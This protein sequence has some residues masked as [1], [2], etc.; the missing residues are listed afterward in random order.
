MAHAFRAET[1]QMPLIEADDATLAA[2]NHR[3]V[4]FR[5][6]LAEQALLDDDHL[7][8][9]IEIAAAAG[10]EHYNL[11]LVEEDENG[12]PRWVQGLLSNN[13]QVDGARVL[14]M[15]RSGRLWL[16]IEHLAELAPHLHTLIVDAFDELSARAKG[17][18]YRNLYCNLLISGP[19]A[20]VTPHIDAAEVIL[21][22]IRGR[23]RMWLYD[24]AEFPVP[25]RTVESIIL[26]E[27]LEDIHFPEEWDGKGL[28]LDA[29][30]GMA[31]SFPYL[32]THS[33]ENLG[34][35]NVSLQTEYHHPRS[36]R[37]YGALFASG[38]ARRRLG[39]EPA[40]ADPGSLAESLRAMVGLA[41]KALHLNRE[42]E[43]RIVAAFVIDENAEGHVRRFTSDDAPV[44]SK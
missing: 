34:E 17:F 36:I 39:M 41:A 11:S 26:R 27:Q 35:L 22:H 16:Q 43:R 29:E 15:I 10:P 40:A 4:T 33:V 18:S 13:G 6:G 24:P 12:A 25:E 44:L 37:R 3:P 42:T 28:A 7:A 38:L 23:K 31:I 14:N 2:I 1:G 21:W 9:L 32:W 8:R 30:P 5:H 20:R 19:Q